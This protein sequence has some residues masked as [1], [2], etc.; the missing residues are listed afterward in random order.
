E[1]EMRCP[2]CKRCRSVGSDTHELEALGEHD[3]SAGLHLM[4]K[5]EEEMWLVALVGWVNEDRA[6][7]EELPV[8]LQDDVAGGEHQR[9]SGMQHRRERRTSFV[10]PHGFAREA[11]ALVLLEH[12]RE[13]ASVAA[14]DQ[15]IAIADDL[16]HV[17]DLESL[18]FAGVHRAAE[19][20]ERLR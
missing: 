13:L 4:Q 7:S 5:H 20:I 14:G 1:I 18:G 9:M 6:L 12:R 17:R 8:A 11:D 16:G 2:S 3:V 10:E 15:A 19:R